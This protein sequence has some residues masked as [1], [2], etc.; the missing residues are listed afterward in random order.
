[1]RHL[2]LI[3]TLFFFFS[4]VGSTQPDL[5]QIPSLDDQ[6]IVYGEDPGVA[7]EAALL[8]EEVRTDL[9]KTLGWINFNQA[10]IQIWIQE[11]EM[12]ASTAFTTTQRKEGIWVKKIEVPF[13]PNLNE[14]ILIRE[15][16]QLLLAD[17]AFEKGRSGNLRPQLNIPLWVVEGLR[18]KAARRSKNKNRSQELGN[19]EFLLQTESLSKDPLQNQHFALTAGSFIDFLFSLPEGQ[20]KIKHLIRS[21]SKPKSVFASI[22]QKDFKSNKELQLAWN[23]FSGDPPVVD[24]PRTKNRRQ[25]ILHYLDAL[26]AE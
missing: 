12:D 17:L 15:I 16:I 21:Y 20:Q 3:G 13:Q 6:F 9:F 8:A 18:W 14:E 10:P 5:Y 11:G 4:S 22:Y 24:S 23:Q 26:E 2:F 1:V 19:L 7:Q 25:I